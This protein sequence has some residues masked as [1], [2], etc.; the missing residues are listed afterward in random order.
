MSSG[1]GPRR[2]LANE[3]DLPSCPLSARRVD[4]TLS[5]IR[6]RPSGGQPAI[7]WQSIEP[8]I[9]DAAIRCNQKVEKA[10]RDRGP[11]A[12]RYCQPKACTPLGLSQTLIYRRVHDPHGC[13]QMAQY[14][15]SRTPTQ[16]PPIHGQCTQ[17]SRGIFVSPI[18]RD[19]EAVRPATPCQLHHRLSRAGWPSHHDRSM[20]RRLPS[21]RG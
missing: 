14:L 17:P 13:R 9:R 2:P 6:G 4:G 21:G 12:V 1:C 16:L 10:G 5:C 15:A 7:C 8:D 3:L 19:A 11:A 20:L 18:E